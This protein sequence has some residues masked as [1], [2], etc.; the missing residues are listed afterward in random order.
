MI[1]T[2]HE[3]LLTIP[4]AAKEV[5]PVGISIACAW[6]WAL[7]GTRGRRLDSV[8]I[9]GR[10]YT[11]KQAIERFLNHSHSTESTTPSSNSASRE[12]A[13]AKA[14]AELSAMGL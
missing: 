4:Q 11:S 9:G 8:V 1:D 2:K 10:R 6:R 7:H 13:I 5:P 3:E 14:E 12:K